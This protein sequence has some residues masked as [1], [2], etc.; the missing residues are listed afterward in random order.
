MPKL[1]QIAIG[2][3][4]RT[5]VH[6]AFAESLLR[7]CAYD[8]THW[9]ILNFRVQPKFGGLYLNE[10]R[11]RLTT[12]ILDQWGDEAEV[13]ISLD[14]DHDPAPE[15]IMRLAALCTPERPV[16]SSLYYAV[17]GLGDQYRPSMLRRN[18]EGN[19]SSVWDFPSG[20][21]VEVDVVGM[22]GCAIRMDLLKQMRAHNGDHWFDFDTAENGRFMYEDEAFCARVQEFMGTKIYVHTGIVLGHFKEV[23]VAES[24][25]RQA[26]VRPE[27]QGKALA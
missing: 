18:A 24:K 9:N 14:T 2:Y 13:F 11:N 26:S 16:V 20:E 8:V 27:A 10:G 19:L 4:R 1:P 17:D 5:Q 12:Q 15:D 23:R 21:L 6:G 3:C 22:G 7:L 25:K